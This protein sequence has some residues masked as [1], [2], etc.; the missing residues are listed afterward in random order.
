MG[1]A[2]RQYQGVR[3][4]MEGPL[5]VQDHEVIEETEET[6]IHPFVVA[7]ESFPATLAS[8]MGANSHM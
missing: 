4:E 1:L 6:E 2:T 8:F 3:G 5:P 7:D